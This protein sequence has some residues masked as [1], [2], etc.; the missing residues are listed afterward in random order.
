MEKATI[1]QLKNRLS[2]YLRLVR[3][4]KTVLVYDR[5]HPVARIEKLNH[6]LGADARLKRLESRGMVNRATR[7]VPLDILKSLA[8][9]AKHSVLKALLEDR[10]EGR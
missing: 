8:P 3:Q 10:K 2:A 6:E 5:N 7:A 9:R 1:A 4:G